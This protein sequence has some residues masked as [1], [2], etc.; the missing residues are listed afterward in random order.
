M[1]SIIINKSITYET[2]AR[3]H[4]NSFSNDK[5]ENSHN[6][7]IV[8]NTDDSHIS[9]DA[10]VSYKFLNRIESSVK[11]ITESPFIE[12]Y[13]SEYENIKKE[14]NSG[15][16][17]KN[18]NNYIDLLDN[19]FKGALNHASNILLKS[20]TKSDSIKLSSSALTKCQKQYETAT[21]LVWIFRVEHKKVLKEIEEYKKKKNHEKV[22]SLT[23]LSNTY[24]HVINNIS[25]NI[26]FMQENINKSFE[27]DSYKLED[28]DKLT[29]LQGDQYS[30]T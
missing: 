11:N 25:C 17:G 1:D 21:S 26:N 10:M 30:S 14:I 9:S 7:T 12:K 18:I 5:N 8:Q 15:I 19:A 2:N 20:S 27:R 13:N 16:Y 24:K 22:A 28:C 4:K 3:E 6:N 29:E 23:Q